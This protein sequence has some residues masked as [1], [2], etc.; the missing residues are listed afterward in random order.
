M[1]E[2]RGRG[3]GVV[4]EAQRD[5]AGGEVLADPV[6]VAARRH[7]LDGDAIGRLRIVLVEQGAHQDAPLAPPGGG[8]DQRAGL[9]RCLA[10]QPRGFLIIVL[11][12]EPARAHE[13][14]AG[15]VARAPRHRVEPGLGV[16]RMLEHRRP[17][18][19][20]GEFA[21][22]EPVRGAHAGLDVVLIEALRHAHLVVLRRDQLAEHVED[23]A[24]DRLA[25]VLVAPGV[26]HECRGAGLVALGEQRVG[27]G[28]AA[29]GR[30]R[31]PLRKVAEHRGV[32]D[33]VVPQRILGA[34]GEQAGMRPVRMVLDEIGVALEAGVGVVAAQDHPFGERLGDR[35]LDCGFV[36]VG[37]VALL[38]RLDDLLEGGEIGGRGL[39]GGCDGKCTLGRAP[40][41]FDG[42]VAGEHRAAQ[43][44]GG[45]GEGGCHPGGDRALARQRHGGGSFGSRRSGLCRRHRARVRRGHRRGGRHSPA[46]PNAGAQRAQPQDRPACQARPSSAPR[47]PPPSRRIPLRHGHSKP[48]CRV[49]PLTCG[50]RPTQ[51]E[52]SPPPLGQSGRKKVPSFTGTATIGGER[53]ETGAG[54]ATT[55]HGRF[56]SFMRPPEP[57]WIGLQ[58]RH[59]WEKSCHDRQDELP[60]LL[61]RA[62]HAVQKRIGGRT[63]LPRSGGV[64]DRGGH[65]RAGAGRH[66]G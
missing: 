6:D 16:A 50:A 44:E 24:L 27:E 25:A 32:L 33:A 63:G 43:T 46:G 41:R 10:H 12:D 34:P 13:N 66:H 49:R 56:W 4:Q 2:Q 19:G 61:H 3:L 15:I 65:Q 42:G 17:G 23:L 62:G 59:R 53:G 40:G 55:R 64:A 45:F 21:A 30:D 29:L 18:A 36:L 52:R 20:D 22:A 5:P 38:G 9:A 57:I 39:I 28:I 31:V 54:T 47:H 35:I 37:V 14:V 48:L 7:R 8:I 26:A 51:A 58:K 11:A 60:G 1:C